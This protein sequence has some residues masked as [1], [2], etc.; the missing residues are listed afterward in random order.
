MLQK[1]M[2]AQLG[3]DWRNKFAEFDNKPFAA[4]S[5]GQVSTLYSLLYS[6]D[7]QHLIFSIL[8]TRSAASIDSFLLII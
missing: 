6:L 8:F 4:A 3:A 2:S 5:I 1:A 7:W